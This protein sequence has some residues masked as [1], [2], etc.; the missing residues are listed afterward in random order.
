M[1]ILMSFSDTTKSQNQNK[2]SQNP[3]EEDYSPEVD[4]MRLSPEE[5]EELRRDKRESLRI[6]R[7]MRTQPNK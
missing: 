3:K 7:E 2:N 1:V 5:I 6:L 4:R